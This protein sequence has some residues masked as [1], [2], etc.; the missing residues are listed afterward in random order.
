MTRTLGLGLLLASSVAFAQTDPFARNFDTVPN[1]A[2]PGQNS[3]IA[4]EGT[5]PNLAGSFRAAFLLD[6]NVN[7]LALTLGDEKLANLLPLRLDAHLLFAYQLHRRFELGV[8]LPVTIYQGSNFDQLRDRGFLEEDPASFGLG[9]LRVIPR[10]FLL[11]EEEFWLGVAVALEVR[12]PTGDGQSFRGDRRATFAPRVLLS[13]TFGKLRLLGNAGMRIREAGQYLNLLVD[14][15]IT[16]GA[17]AIYALPDLG[18]F[19]RVEAV[20]EMHFATPRTDPFTFDKGDSLK[21]PWEVLLGLRGRFTPRWG[22]EVD[23]GRVVT[24]SSGYGREDF[25]LL[26]QVNYTFERADRDGDTIPDDRDK[27]QDQKEDIDGFE[28]GDGC[29]DPDNDKDTVLDFE[30]VCPDD[31]GTRDM[32]GCPDRD[33]DEI[34]DPTD[35]CPDVPGPPENDGCPFEGPT[36]VLET[37]RIRVRGNIQFDFNS[38]VIKKQSHPL[39]DDTYEVLKKNPDLGLVRIEG[40]T[41]NIGARS[42]NLDLSKRRA[43]AVVDYLVKKGIPRTQLV[44]EGYGFD[45]P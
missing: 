33:Q 21:S 12:A 2:T 9:D 16:L 6:L 18:R 15:E 10:L 28:D 1:K 19:R 43:G 14:D 29:P 4:L 32:D 42:Y 22:L 3:G 37:D 27:C 13:H 24:T 25:R 38:S 8:D 5:Q 17:G 45:R 36:V 44:S 11:T 20:G 30:D 34:P 26:A 7:T 23:V 40:H 35:K 39:L 31:P 41:D